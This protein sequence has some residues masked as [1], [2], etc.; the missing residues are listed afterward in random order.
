MRRTA[1]ALAALIALAAAPA[2]AQTQGVR[3]HLEWRTLRTEHFD[4]HYPAELE[5][6]TLDVASRLEPARARVAALVGS[7]PGERVTVVVEDPAGVT[8]GF[9]FALPESPTI[10]LWPTPPAP[11]SDLANNRGQG[12]LLAVHEF[13]HIAHLT[14]PSRNARDRLWTRLIPFRAGPVARRTPRWV[15]EGYATRVEGQLTGSGRPHGVVRAAVLR[16]WALEGRLPTYAQLDATGTFQGGSMAYLAGSAFLDWLVA[17]RGQ[18]SLEHLWRR[19]SARQTRS[20]DEAFAG[21]FG[22]P[23]AD[24]Y[25][26]FTVEVTA[27]ALEARARLAA[28]G[29]ED[30]DTL[31]AL[32]WM[33]G[34]PAVSPDGEHLAL[35]LGGA[36]GTASRV[37]VWRTREERGD[38]AVDAAR[39]RLLERDPEDVA[40]IE[41]RPRPRRVLATLV[42]SGGSAYVQPRFLPGGEEI[43][44]I[45]AAPLGDG[46]A[47][48]DLFAWAWRRGE[49]RRIT[50]GASLRAA[51]PFPG[52]ERAAATR[53]EAGICDLVTVELASGAVRLLSP[54][55]PSVVFR[56]SRVSP[57][58]RTVAVSLQE[59]GRWRVA[60]VDAATGARRVLDAGDG[61]S[62]YEPAWLPGGGL[63]AVSER[64]GVANLAR[65]DAATGALRPLTRVTGAA[66]A[67]E[68]D[69][70]TGAV[71]FLSLHPRGLDLHRLHPDSVDVERLVALDPS[72]A[73]AA[74]PERVAADTLPRT[75]LPPSRPYGIGPRRWRVLPAGAT[76]ADGTSAGGVLAGTDPVGRLTLLG[77]ALLATDGGEAGAAL[78]AVWR[79]WRP[80]VGSTVFWQRHRPA[81][82]GVAPAALDTDY[83]GAALWTEHARQGG[84]WTRTLRAGASAGRLAGDDAGDA[85]G[86]ATGDADRQLAFAEGAFTATRTRGT[87]AAGAALRLHGTAGRTGGEAWRRGVASATLSWTSRRFSLRGDALLGRTADDAPTWERFTVGG[88]A[89]RLVSPSLLSQRVALPGLPLGAVRGAEATLLRVSTRVG[90]VAPFY[91]AAND[92]GREWQRLVGVEAGDEIARIPLIGL[93]AIR[94]L[95]GAAYA[96]DE[97]YRRQ[98]R[99]WV[100]VTFRP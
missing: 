24:L 92:G 51:D 89:P 54:G 55:A 81:R 10:V 30:G 98:V 100:S 50:R 39:R 66:V 15:K 19:L 74:P 36:P 9:A 12:E 71:F 11:R 7:A 22:G 65:V 72:L 5:R 76:D 87:S 18:E 35:S 40:A 52:G 73:P 90:G 33:T 82:N 28:A 88:A 44:V 41:W 56:R 26:R 37:V 97:P 31:Q 96:L 75:A 80:A 20:F 21:V 49:L 13:A 2:A 34:D 83:A 95:A 77:Q 46:A 61:A 68:T 45:R 69:P 94:F 62:V 6:W 3:P 14:R 59:G 58:G 99:A 27:R 53:C 64:G 16:Q 4:V 29:L 23:P 67:P 32:S 42:P 1:R 48:P 17:Q 70:A 93:P 25:G 85:R 63:V 79:G 78:D 84:A 57:D 86:D 38:S 91:A 47:R 8:N 43:L 60:L